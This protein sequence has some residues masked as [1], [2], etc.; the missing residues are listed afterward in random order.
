ML[1]ANKLRWRYQHRLPSASKVRWVAITCLE[2]L[3]LL[4]ILFSAWAIVANNDANAAPTP[5]QE[6]KAAEKAQKR[7][8]AREER[9]AREVV[10][11][12]CVAS[13]MG[14]CRS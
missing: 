11:E 6:R 2:A 14:G 1:L 7:A 12:A 5:A 10:Y 9:R 3:L 8:L 4:T 13:C